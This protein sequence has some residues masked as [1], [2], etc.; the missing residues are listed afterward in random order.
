MPIQAPTAAT[1]PGSTFLTKPVTNVVS[2]AM[3]SAATSE[4]H[5]TVKFVE[6]VS[7][8]KAIEGKHLAFFPS[9]EDGPNAIVPRT[10]TAVAMNTEPQ[11]ERRAGY[12]LVSMRT[13]MD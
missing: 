7:L 9:M 4:A 5:S 3:P 13:T 8:A 2:V 10:R 1:Q 12:S 6:P 11:L